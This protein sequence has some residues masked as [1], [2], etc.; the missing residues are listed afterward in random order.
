MRVHVNGS[1]HDPPVLGLDTD[2]GTFIQLQ[3]PADFGNRTISNQN[4]QGLV[5]VAS[6]VY[7][8]RLSAN[9]ETIIKRMTLTK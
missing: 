5:K 2:P 4:I 1:G 9:D 8:Y 7:F 3:I 6:G